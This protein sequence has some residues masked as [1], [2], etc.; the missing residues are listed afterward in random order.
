MP[1]GA[2]Y[3]HLDNASFSRGPQYWQ[4][5][6]VMHYVRPGAVRTEAV[7]DAPAVR[8]LAFVH[9]GRTTVVLINNTPPR[10]PRSGA[11]IAHNRAIVM[12]LR[13]MGR[14]ILTPGVA[15]RSTPGYSRLAAP[16]QR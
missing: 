8:A 12:P 16:R 11:T 5:R 10:K 7:S 9:K 2:F 6:Q 3:L 14:T 4:Y 13:G 15:L 1:G